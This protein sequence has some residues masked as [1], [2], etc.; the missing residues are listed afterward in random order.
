MQVEFE[1]LFFV[2]N[3]IAFELVAGYSLSY[4]KNT[5]G[6]PSMC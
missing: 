5:C 4:E 2:Y 6:R 1:K 3:I